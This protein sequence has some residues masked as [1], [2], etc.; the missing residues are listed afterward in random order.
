M[1]CNRQAAKVSIKCAVPNPS[2]PSVQV[3]YS[4]TV[5]LYINL[6]IYILVTFNP[7]I[8]QVTKFQPNSMVNTRQV[9]NIVLT[10]KTNFPRFSI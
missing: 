4:S 7:I 10:K 3:V 8:E 9:E 2:I 6:Y 1:K 5:Y